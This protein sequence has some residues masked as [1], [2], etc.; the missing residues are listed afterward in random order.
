MSEETPQERLG[1]V[2]ALVAEEAKR[3]D[4]MSHDRLAA[5]LWRSVDR[6][7]DKLSEAIEDA[8][9][10]AVYMGHND[11]TRKTAAEDYAAAMDGVTHC[12]ET[13]QHRVMVAAAV[14]P[15]APHSP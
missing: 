8:L 3:L 6:A 7:A 15:P 2:Q 5:A 11:A 13:L 4:P 9:T 14:S 1:R 10:Q 12:V